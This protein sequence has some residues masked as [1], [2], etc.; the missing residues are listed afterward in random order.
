MNKKTPL[1]FYI[2]KRHLDQKSLFLATTTKKIQK[3]KVQWQ[4]DS[5]PFFLVLC[6]TIE[7]TRTH[8]DCHCLFR[9]LLKVLKGKQS[10][11]R[12]A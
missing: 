7:K 4:I 10:F 1:H 2:S 8:E 3:L 6:I 11:T 12:V 9:K 5:R